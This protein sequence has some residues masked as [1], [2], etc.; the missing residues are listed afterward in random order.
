[1]KRLLLTACIAITT[2]TSL[3][4]A[5]DHSFHHGHHRRIRE[6]RTV[7]NRICGT[8]LHV[9]TPVQPTYI[10]EPTFTLEQPHPRRVENELVGTWFST[11]RVLVIL[12]GQRFRVYWTLQGQMRIDSG[13]YVHRG[14]RI[15]FLPD[16][17]A[18][19]PWSIDARE[20]EVMLLSHQDVGQRAFLRVQPN[21]PESLIG[22]FQAQYR[23]PTQNGF[24]E[25]NLSR[26][27]VY[28]I[29]EYRADGS[30]DHSERGIWSVEGTTFNF[31]VYSDAVNQFVSVPSRLQYVY[32]G[33]V[34]Q[35]TSFFGTDYT[36][37]CTK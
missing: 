31:Y 27:G 20:G 16:N 12:P 2:L 7:A 22:Q 17:G 36:Y 4:L 8:S 3:V 29:H 14:S 1:M 9:H 28:V 21:T 25:V 11:D 34:L 10:D 33:F 37:I 32:N 24:A 15:D 35:F 6:F 5:G 23:T 30:L 19:W 13:R 18:Y 26:D